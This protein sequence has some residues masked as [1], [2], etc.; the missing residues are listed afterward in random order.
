MPRDLNLALRIRADLGNA[1]AA[2][3]KLD[4]SLDGVEDTAAAAADDLGNIDG[5][6]DRAARGLNRMDVAVGAF[7]ANIA[8]GALARAVDLLAEIPAAIVEGG[9]EIERL[10]A[11]FTFAAGSI[12]QGAQDLQFARQEAE[13]LAIDFRTAADAYSAIAAAAR[14]TS[15][16]GRGAQE[17][18][19]GISEAARVLQLDASRTGLALRAVEQIMSKGVLSAEELRQQMGDHIPGAFQ[20]AARAMG[21]STGEL[22]RMISRGEVASEVFLPKFAR[23]LREEFG[24]AVPAAV[25][26]ADA[27]FQRFGNAIERL[28][29]AVARSGFLDFLADAADLAAS[30]ADSLSGIEVRTTNDELARLVELE[31]RRARIL[32]GDTDGRL[33]PR[34]RRQV[35]ELEGEIAEIEA[36]LAA[37][38]EV[39][40]EALEAIAK[41]AREELDQV[42]ARL[43]ELRTTPESTLRGRRG[44]QERTEQRRETE[45]LEAR[46][47]AAT[48]RLETAER[49]ARAAADA[50]PDRE[51]D[52]VDVVGEP[53]DRDAERAA[54]RLL[55]IQERAEDRRFRATRDRIGLTL[56]AEQRLVDE[57]EG[58]V[59]EGLVTAERAEEVR[60]AVQA[61]GA[62]ERERIHADEEKARERAAA[63]EER[64]ARQAERLA[65]RA[66]RAQY[67]A[68]QD[69]ADLEGELEGPYAEAVASVERWEARSISAFEAAGLSAEEY[70]ETVERV[71]AQRLAEAVTEETDRRL[72]ESRR[73][74][75][76]ARRALADYEDA[77][78]DAGRAAEEALTSGLRT[79]EDA[80]VEFARTGKFEFSSLADSIV[81]DLARIATRQA[82]TGPLAAALGSAFGG[83]FGGSTIPDI[84]H[85]GGVVGGGARRTRTGVP[86]YVFAGAPRLHRGGIAGLRP[87]EVPTILERG[88]TVRTAEQERD[89]SRAAAPRELTVRIENRGTPQRVE[90]ASVDVDVH[91]LVVD[92]MV[93]D[94]SRGGRSADAIGALTGGGGL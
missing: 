90:Q 82:I 89:L 60:S 5:A 38:G 33:S 16:E 74:V 70:G 53:V 32:A 61:A 57:I 78:T 87:N 81:A 36:R 14:D 71:V 40:A 67:E 79:M 44:A 39:G 22:D 23:Q 64:R 48:R 85:S 92:I 50:A 27:S 51:L 65:E 28:E 31:A 80:F 24:D 15:L 75:D 54:R 84:A 46:L 1:I 43:E 10:E 49:L 17:I 83:S 2:L 93:D 91:G 86:A 34:Q 42:A 30:V 37:T 69:L 56:A 66:R 47:D 12:A 3:E 25:E 7:A 52:A 41:Q 20:I 59:E 94:I 55:A 21:V 11:R 13:R 26:T 63:A 29:E 58:L 45:A 19:I 73:W 72:R 68:L 77:A 76:G 4:R 18:F 35:T 62:A 9:R 6:T 88:E 8:A